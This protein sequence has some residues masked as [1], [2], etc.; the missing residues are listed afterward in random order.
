LI[1]RLA[2]FLPP[3]F[4]YI[5]EVQKFA[6]EPF[7]RSAV[8]IEP[9]HVHDTADMRCSTA[10]CTENDV[11]KERWHWQTAFVLQADRTLT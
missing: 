5:A 11:F 10:T 8:D 4:A 1:N 6:L 7:E 3:A 9:W 2:C